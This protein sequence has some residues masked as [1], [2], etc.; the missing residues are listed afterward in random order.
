MVS[1]TAKRPRCA[2]VHDLRFAP[3]SDH[4]SQPMAMLR[5]DARFVAESESVSSAVRLGLDVIRPCDR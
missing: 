2:C 1:R 3:Q 5:L 4:S